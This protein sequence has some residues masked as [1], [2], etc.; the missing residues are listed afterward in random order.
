MSS[1]QRGSINNPQHHEIEQAKNDLKHYVNCLKSYH[2]S[3]PYLSERMDLIGLCN[4]TLIWLI[5]ARIDS[6]EQVRERH[7]YLR[8]RDI[9]IRQ[10]DLDV[11]KSIH[12]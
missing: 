10:T 3:R 2:E 8:A 11:N 6:I 7:E 5:N 4:S 1:F 12:R 9:K